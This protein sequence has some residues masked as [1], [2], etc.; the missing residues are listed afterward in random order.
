MAQV[1]PKDAAD[2][3]QQLGEVLTAPAAERGLVAGTQSVSA[4]SGQSKQPGVHMSQV[5]RR[6]LN[7]ADA[8]ACSLSAGSAWVHGTRLMRN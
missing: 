1:P 4:G 3:L 7:C 6:L 8:G 2:L 5:V